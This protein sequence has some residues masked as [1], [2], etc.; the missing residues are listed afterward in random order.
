MKRLAVI[1]ILLFTVNAFAASLPTS[2]S[3]LISDSGIPLYSNATF[4]NGTKDVGFRFASSMKPEEVQKW[5]RQQ[6]SDWALYKESG[7]WILYNGEPGKGMTEVMSE[8]QVMVKRNDNL[9]EWFSLEKN[10][11]TE[12]VIMIVK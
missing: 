3:K 11:T 7:G 1:L 5:Y 2:D 8:N 10:M 6:L 9:P 12:I 4:V